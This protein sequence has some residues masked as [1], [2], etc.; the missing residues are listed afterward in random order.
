[1][2]SSKRG[3]VLALAGGFCVLWSS[4][5]IAGKFGLRSAPPLFLLAV[6]FLFAGAIMIGIARVLRHG[7]LRRD[8][9]P[10]VVALGLLNNTL[11]LGLTFVGLKTVSSGLVTVI[12]SMNPLL[13]ALVAHPVLGERLSLRKLGGLGLGIGGVIVIMQHRMSLGTDSAYGVG[14][15]AL[16]TTA[17]VGGTILFKKT[18][19]QSSLLVI[20]G[21]QTLF[22]G[23]ALV[24]FTLCLEPLGSIQFDAQLYV[25]IA[26]LVLAVSGAS[27]LIWFWLLK[28][29]T[30]S[31]A[32]AFHFLNPVIGLVFAYLILGEP[33]YTLDFIGI[34]LVAT[35]IMIV[36]RTTSRDLV[37]H[38]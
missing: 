4:A 16:G 29:T 20:N 23:I 27:V 14:L 6:R 18:Q 15:V 24:P 17:L 10:R 22:G 36:T 32:S 5:F 1:M 8:E 12:V 37:K 21:V 31:A 3:L 30:A 38:E 7:S 11:Y 35:G 2:Q 26:Y 13:T 19:L 33:L 25:S 28:L 34:V 9:W